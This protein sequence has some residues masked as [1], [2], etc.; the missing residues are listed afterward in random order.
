[1]M[2]IDVLHYFT[3]EEQDALLARAAAAVRAGGRLVVREADTERGWRSAVTLLE[4][5]VFTAARFNRGERVRMR[6]AREIAAR[7]VE[8]GL[9][10][11]V[12]PAWGRTPFSNVLIVGRR[13]ARR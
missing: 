6:P 1:V 8:A 9:A 2:L 7:L 12:R 13:A 4:E 10:C 11:E 3:I 5:R